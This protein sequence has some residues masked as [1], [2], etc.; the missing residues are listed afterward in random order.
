LNWADGEGGTK[1]IVVTILSG[2]SGTQ[3]FNVI[4][5]TP[6][7]GIVIGATANAEV[8]IY[9]AGAPGNPTPGGSIA[10]QLIDEMGPFN[11]INIFSSQ[12][13]ADE[14]VFYFRQN[15]LYGGMF[16]Q[17]I[18]SVIGFSGGVPGGLGGSP[19][20]GTDPNDGGQTL[21]PPFNVTKIKYAGYVN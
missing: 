9:A 15:L 16:G 14:M 3:A 7:G 4:I 1:N 12:L 18:G 21:I 17:K 8:D 11:G 13:Y 10:Q 2:G 19:G 6:T 5:D 20:N